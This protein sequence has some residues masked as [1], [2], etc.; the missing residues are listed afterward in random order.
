MRPALTFVPGWGQS[1]RVWYNQ[2]AYFSTDWPVQ[3]LNLPGH[4]HAPDAPVEYWMDA[5]RDALPDRPCILAGWSLGGMLAMQLALRWP[6]RLA[7][8]VLVSS[9][10]CFRVKT[11]WEQGCSD[12]QFH[13]FEQALERDSAKLTGYFFTLMLRGEAVS[14]ARFHTIAKEA[15]DRRHPPSP[16]A[17]RSG[18]ALLDAL[19][20]RAQLANISIP[21]MVIHGTHDQVTPVGAGHYLAGHIPDASLHTMA[22]GHAP[23]LTQDKIFNQYLERWCLNIT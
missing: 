19:D 2:S 23:H 14:R 1:S 9:T 22:C 3:L 13:A 6:E 10:P 21:V 12:E 11:D 7:G 5:L 15:V 4:G 16:E 8:L 20:L 18:L 17:L